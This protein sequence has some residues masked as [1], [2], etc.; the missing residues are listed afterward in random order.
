MQVDVNAHPSYRFEMYGTPRVKCGQFKENWKRPQTHA[1]KRLN[2]PS[3][4]RPSLL[5]NFERQTTRY[6]LGLVRLRLGVL[7]SNTS[8]GPPILYILST[9]S[10]TAITKPLTNDYL[11]SHSCGSHLTS[12]R[13][14]TS[15]ES[16]SPAR[17]RASPPVL[18]MTNG[19]GT[20][21]CFV[22]FR[23]DFTCHS[24]LFDE[25]FPPILYYHRKAKKPYS[26]K[27]S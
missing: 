22:W 12:G 24:I 23:D 9:S 15:R 6:L 8:P 2:N 5:T 20:A 19:R 3:D 4:K 25:R 27:T 18:T 26:Q 11:R 17:A 10:Y 14:A 21:Y 13:I 7:I 1:K 16:M